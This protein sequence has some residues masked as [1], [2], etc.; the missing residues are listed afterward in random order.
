MPTKS[1]L[2]ALVP[3]LGFT[4]N[5]PEAGRPIRD[6]ADREEAIIARTVAALAQAERDLAAL[7][8]QA[9]NAIGGKWSAEEIAEA[10]AVS[11]R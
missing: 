7:R 11:A 9:A 5:L 2:D 4:R 6:Y 8:T 3:T 1:I 10:K